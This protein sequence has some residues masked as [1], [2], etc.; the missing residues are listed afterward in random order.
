MPLGFAPLA[1]PGV[2]FTAGQARAMDLSLAI[3]VDQQD[4]TVTSQTAG[5]SVASDENASAV[6]IK[7]SDL[8]ALSDDPSELQNELQALAGPAAGPNGGEIYIDGFSGG[9]IP[10]K[11]AIR[12]IRVNQNPFSA[13]FEHIGYGRIEILTKPGSDKFSG[14]MGAFGNDSSWD[15]GN[16][17]VKTL[18]SYYAY[19]NQADVNGPLT[20]TASYF[21][22]F[23][24]ASRQNQSVID[25][26]DPNNTSGSINET[27]PNPSSVIEGNAR[28]DFQF[29]KANTLSIRDAFSNFSSQGNGVGQF[30]LASQASSSKNLEND[31][32]VS[33]TIVV[34]T[35][36]INETHFQWRRIRNSQLATSFAPTV[37]VQGAFTE[38]GASSGVSQDHQDDFE[39]QNYSTANLGPHVVRFGARLRSYRDANYAKS[40]ANGT[41]SFSSIPEFLAGTPTQYQV[42]IFQNPLARLQLFDG[43]FFYQD[44]WRVRPNLTLSDGLRF[45]TQNRIEDHADI[46]PRFALAWAPWHSGAKPPKTV[47]RA[48]YG[49]F[50]T[51]FT[52]PSFFGGGSTP[53]LIQAIHKNGI[54]QQNY[55]V[56]NLDPTLYNPAAPV[57]PKYVVGATGSTPTTYTI[58]PRFHA[59]LDMQGGIGVDQQFRKLTFNVSYLFTRGVHE[60]LTDNITA[61]LFDPSTYTLSGSLPSVFNYQYQS[62]GTYKQQQII[63]S[64]NLGLK[65]F[66]LHG[67]Y[68]WNDAHSDTQ[69][70][71]Y[72]PSVSQKPSLDYGRAGFG[73]TSRA[74]LLGTW[75]FPHAVIFAPLLSAQSGTPYNITTGYDYTGNN[76]FNARP[77]YGACGAANVVSTPFGC[78]DTDPVGKGEQI[79]PYGLGTGPANY[80][81]H[82]RVSKAIGIGPRIKGA[83]GPNNMQ[84]NNGVGGR[85]LSAGQAQPK[86]D[87]SVPRKYNLTLAVAAINALN[88]VNLAPPNGTL[89]SPL[90]G[91]SQALAGGP[92]GS[93]VPGNRFVMAQATFAF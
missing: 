67:N 73:I 3:A 14:H 77:T 10:P 92:Y 26:V 22:N 33:D 13:E 54:N 49:W 50:Y 43:A 56:D 32:Q 44:E 9:Q 46:A 17:L 57:D 35:R 37:T 93:P 6:V 34:N 25:A 91:K 80:V 11:S 64:G 63:V 79:V 70:A 78:L 85:G 40:G 55:V 7:G 21:L 31:F 38:G 84:G 45:E 86:I 62:E 58:D 89:S 53:Y 81:L 52:V 59:A 66:S 48:G 69:G 20:K 1:K 75:N 15:T 83:S 61:P 27:F 90:F 51:R 28:V 29:G 4:V 8:D 36:L 23:F 41:Y 16:P 19:F 5:V 24:R 2:V 71:S 12:E 30:N 87:A 76:Q 47:V 88:I 18:P 39:L 74:F 82:L 72:V 42:T 68:T 65:K 60:Y